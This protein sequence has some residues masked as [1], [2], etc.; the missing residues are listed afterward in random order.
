MAPDDQPELT[1]R[2]GFARLGVNL[3]GV[4]VPG[5]LIQ[6]TLARYATN[7]IVNNQGDER[8]KLFIPGSATAVRYRGAELMLVTQHQLKDIDQSQVAMLTDSGGHIVTTSGRR[9]YNLH[10]DTD[11]NDIVAFNFTAPCEEFPELKT[12]FFNLTAIP[13]H[14]VPDSILAMLLVGFPSEAQDYDL[15]ENN[16]L[17]FR[18]LQVACLPHPDQPSDD[19]LLRVKPIQPLT[20]DPNG[21]S[22]GAAFVVQYA[23]GEPRAYFAGMII[24]G[25]REDFYILKSG[26]IMAFLDSIFP[27][28]KSVE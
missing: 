20:V 13:A 14:F 8:M 5:N 26:V 22:G 25:G 11:A 16:R 21:M 6:Q 4:I 18:R 2:D 27:W 19:A 17:G 24:R 12:R 1:I 15:Y 3:N 23:D 10:P 9:G 28:D 7:L